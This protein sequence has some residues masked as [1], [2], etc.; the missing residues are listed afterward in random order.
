MISREPIPIR[1]GRSTW[2]RILIV[3]GVVLVLLLLTLRQLATF[4]TD[5]LWFDS[6]DRTGVWST[7]VWT[8]VLLAVVF[9][10]VAFLLIWLNTWPSS[11]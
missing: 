1:S 7:L 6:I 3:L 8:R 11:E 2:R 9:S 10:V 5:Y 4:W